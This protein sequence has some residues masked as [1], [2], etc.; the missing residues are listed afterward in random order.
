MQETHNISPLVVHSGLD[1]LGTPQALKLLLP[2]ALTTTPKWTHTFQ[3]VS[4]LFSLQHLIELNIFFRKH[5]P[6]IFLV[7]YFSG[8]HSFCWSFP[9]SFR[10]KL[11]SWKLQKIKAGEREKSQVI[12]D[13]L[14]Q[15][16]ESGLYSFSYSLNMGV[17][18]IS[19][20][21]PHLSSFPIC[22][23]GYLGLSH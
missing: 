7:L 13:L 21:S 19:V 9:F 10:V 1:P 11:V 22:S 5:A 17:I 18:L 2:M 15:P 16:T 14:Y 12:K 6:L 3:S 4:F 8:F 23:P 20:L